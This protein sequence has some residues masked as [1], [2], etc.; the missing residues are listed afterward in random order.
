MLCHNPGPQIK[1]FA[2][3]FIGRGF[4]VTSQKHLPQ[5]VECLA[6]DLGGGLLIGD[7]F[8]DDGLFG[9]HLLRTCPY[10]PC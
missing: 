7:A 9:Q 10:P 4:G 1:M 3:Q 6:V 5:L 8:R 2:C